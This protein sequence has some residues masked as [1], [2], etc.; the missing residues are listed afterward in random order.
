MKIKNINRVMLSRLVAVAA[1]ALCCVMALPTV[2]HAEDVPE[3]KNEFHIKNEADF[4]LCVALSRERDTSGWHVYLDNDIEL[5]SDDMKAIVATPL[6]ICRLATRSIRL[7]ACS[8]VK[9]TPLRA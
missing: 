4:L 8:M 2:V 1:I 7:R 6:S 5:D 9:T 3:N